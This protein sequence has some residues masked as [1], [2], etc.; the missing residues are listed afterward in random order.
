VL[1]IVDVSEPVISFRVR[2]WSA[3]HASSK[4]RTLSHGAPATGFRN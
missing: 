2:R 3:N 1:A 4:A